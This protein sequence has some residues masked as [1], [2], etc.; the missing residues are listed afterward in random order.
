MKTSALLVFGM[1]MLTAAASAQQTA[2]IRASTEYERGALWQAFFGDTWRDVWSSTITVPVLDIGSYAGGL[3]PFK[4]GGNQSKTLRFHGK[5]GYTYIFRTS[6]KDVQRRA[7]PDDLRHTPIGNVIQDQTSSMHPSG[8]LVVNV[9]QDALGILHAPTTLVY[10]PDD[11]RLGKYRKEFANQLGY[12]EEWPNEVEKGK[13]LGGAEKIVSTE[14][15]LEHLEASMEDR[16]DSR[17]YLK[18]RMFDFVIGDTDRGADQWRWAKLEAGARDVYKPIPRDRD[19]AFMRANGFLIDYA[20]R[21]YPKI[22]KYQ[23]EFPRLM[24][25]VFMTREFD[26]SQLVDLSPA[27]WDS[28]VSFIQQRLTDEVI[29]RAVAQL[30]TAHRELSGS[31][32]EAGLRARRDA[33]R[34]IARRFYLLVN[35]DPDIFASDEDETAEAVRNADGSLDIRIWRQGDTDTAVFV[36]RFEPA[37]TEEVRLYME[38]GADRV[39]VRGDVANSIRLRVV[40]GEDDDV[41][42]D[43]SRVS[44]KGGTI[45]YDAHGNNTYVKGNRTTVIT[46]PY[47]TLPPACGVDPEDECKEE[48]DPR[49]LSE[50]RRGR[51]QDLMNKSRGFVE[52]KIR[53][54]NTRTWGN[55]SGWGMLFGYNA[56]GG[57]ILGFGPSLIDFGFR[58]PPHEWRADLRGLIGMRS[59]DFGVQLTADRY[60]PSTPFSIGI[61]AHTTQLES[62]RFYGFGNNT[63]F[64]DPDQTLVRRSEMLVKPS[65]DYH[66]GKMVVASIGPVLRYVVLRDSVSELGQIGGRFDLLLDRSDNNPR[67]QRGFDLRIGGAAYPAVW[68]IEKAFANAAALAHLYVP[69][70]R[71][72]AAFRVGTQKLWGPFPLHE[73][74]F[75]GGLATVRG[76]EWNRFAGDASAYASAELRVPLVRITLLTRGELGVLGFGDAGRVWLDGASDGGW[77]TSGGIGLSFASL[78]QAVSVMYAHGEE[79][80]LYLSLGL[81]F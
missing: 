12:I 17:E 71:A 50:E 21:A 28:T 67:Q 8:A 44:G 13:T 23:T 69:L 64:A 15:L 68:G 54:E 40:G 79:S 30:P 56:S 22:T 31:L 34:E 55:K 3:E 53:A 25:L 14:R 52:H 19:Y 74:A 70:R 26:R 75:I 72:T 43:S 2:T 60:F 4:T 27:A 11:E 9:L 7:L 57:V 66:I 18:A 81:P 29:S 47:E 33:L 51:Q 1:F 63:P 35:T 46:K 42:I 59:G 77:H 45:F 73:A 24:A 32:I 58:R 39:V 76:V 10:M 36:R 48:K 61:F 80:R 78:G 49:V 5:D 37:E 65:L 16:F 38:R 6:N 41:L 20:A 62:N